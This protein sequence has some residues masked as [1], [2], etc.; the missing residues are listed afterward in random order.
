MEKYIQFK[1]YDE[2]LN[3]TYDKPAREAVLAY[4]RS[5]GRDVMDNPNGQDIDILDIGRRRS[6][7]VEV[8]PAWTGQKHLYRMVNVLH[9]KAH[10][11]IGEHE[12]EPYYAVLNHDCTKLIWIGGEKLKPFI[13]PSNKFLQKH[14]RLP[15]GELRD[16]YV[17]KVP[18]E[19]FEE[20]VLINN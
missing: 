11:F 14:C 1:S 4:L 17:Y 8:R 9:R 16:D 2:E 18:L 10:R 5:Q 13:I 3:N 12:F 15:S 20:L 19:L 6:Y 7:E